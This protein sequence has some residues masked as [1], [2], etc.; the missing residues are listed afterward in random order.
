MWPH[1]RM[2]LVVV[3]CR[4]V[5]VDVGWLCLQPDGPCAPARCAAVAA[6]QERDRGIAMA[7]GYETAV[8]HV[9]LLFSASHTRLS[10]AQ[11]E[12]QSFAVS[13]G[14]MYTPP[15]IMTWLSSSS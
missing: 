8:G 10:S 9:A 1:L 4:A 6:R 13:G 7:A 11:Q 3:A 2:V 12:S 14:A 5:P 15:L